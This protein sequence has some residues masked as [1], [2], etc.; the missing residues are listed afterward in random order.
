MRRAEVHVR[1]GEVE[2]V[3]IGARRFDLR[4]PYYFVLTIT[5]PV[6]FSVV[7]SFYLL[8]NLCFAL[9]YFAVPGCVTNARTGVFFDDFFFS[10]ETLATVGYGVMSP[11]SLYGHIVASTE[12]VYGMMSMAVITGLV[13]VRFSRPR[14]RLMFS[15]VAVVGPLSGKPTLMLRVVNERHEALAEATAR[16]SLLRSVRTQEGYTMRR[17]M[18]M[19]L[20]RATT[21]LLGLSWSLLHPIDES[22]PLWGMTAESLAAEGSYLL[23]SVS[24]Y[25]ESISAPVIGRR[26]YR[27]DR[28]LFGHRFVDILDSRPTGEI[29]IDLT[30]FHD[31]VPIE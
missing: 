12:I 5:W 13:F 27:P 1:L 18:D 24:G 21:P 8:T 22:S 14:A 6:F 17:F 15:Q 26:S 19:K 4:D 2:G 16:L 9:A 7:V 28:I 23:A 30:R 3:K 10:I 31:T 20:D 11:G 29:V 25:D